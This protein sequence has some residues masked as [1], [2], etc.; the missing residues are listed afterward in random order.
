MS[1]VLA[2]PHSHGER[3]GVL[4][5]V[6]DGQTKELVA[7][8][9]ADQHIVDGVVMTGG[10]ALALKRLAEGELP[11]I[12]I[13][14]LSGSTAP[15]A[16][17]AKAVAEAGPGLGILALGSVNDVRLYRDL[18]AAG[19]SDYLVKPLEP[20]HL[21]EAIAIA[22]QVRAAPEPAG[23][24]L[25]R[26]VVF[27]GTR[28]GVGTTTAAVNTAWLIAHEHRRRTALV[29]LDIHFGTVALALDLDPG[30]G[31]RE[32]LEQPSRI[33]SL[34]IERAMVRLGDHLA[35][36]SAEEPMEEDAV[37]D[38]SAVDILLHE[39]Q[40]KFDWV[41]ID[42]P[43][44][45]T[46]I[47]RAVLNVASH[48]VLL[49]EPSLAGLRDAIRLNTLVKDTASHA[50][51]TVLQAGA[52]AQAGKPSVSRGEFE[53][54]LGRKIDVVLPADPKQAT[55]AS[56]AGKALSAV[57]PAVPLVKSFKAVAISLAGP[58]R[59]AKR[60]KSKMWKFLGK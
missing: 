27:A 35:V 21:S 1:A 55:A 18:L 51:V 15:L 30:R 5:V 24:Q 48:V 7:E 41:V 14:D 3:S 17:F 26:I 2:V 44:G 20:H 50:K 57:A 4:A 49:C 19:A 42:M 46:A 13:L 47:Q 8:A 60:G 54:G 10:L 40:Q 43:R 16:D 58:I 6:A 12:L 56:N 11:R 37:F 31:L 22:G 39:L 23:Q 9:L 29:D 52:G 45:M 25:G 33:D 59:G 36:L 53:K 32:A 38:P 28:G 34:F